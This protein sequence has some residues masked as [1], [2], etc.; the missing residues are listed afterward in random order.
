M[1]TGL[2]CTILSPGV[3]TGQGVG[4]VNILLPGALCIPL[5]WLSVLGYAH[6]EGT[7]DLVLCAH[8]VQSSALFDSPI[9]IMWWP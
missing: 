4:T 1:L 3:L 7:V 6:T 9:W 5:N 2:Q 8:T